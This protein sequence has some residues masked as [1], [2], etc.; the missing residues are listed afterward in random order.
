MEALISQH[1]TRGLPLYPTNLHHNRQQNLS[2]CTPINLMKALLTPP[3]LRPPLLT[4][5]WHWSINPFTPLMMMLQISAM[6]FHSRGLA[7]FRSV[8]ATYFS[9]PIT[10]TNNWQTMVQME[11]LLVQICVSSTKPTARL[12]F[13]ALIT[14][15]LLVL[16]WLLL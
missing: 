1:P 4:L 11:A 6:S 9:M 10:P 8:N 14:M 5:Y 3:K 15:K 12:T 16:M 13:K 2:K 7:R